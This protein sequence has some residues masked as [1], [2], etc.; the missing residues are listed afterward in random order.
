[1]KQTGAIQV[2]IQIVAQKL[3]AAWNEELKARRQ[4]LEMR[5]EITPHHLY[6]IFSPKILHSERSLQRLKKIPFILATEPEAK[7]PHKGDHPTGTMQ[8]RDWYSAM[9]KARAARRRISVANAWKEHTK[10]E[11]CFET[12]DSLWLNGTSHLPFSIYSLPSQFSTQMGQSAR[13]LLTSVRNLVYL[14]VG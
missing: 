4:P 5:H 8:F 13:P 12:R 6:M 2:Q 1:M 11:G 10:T 7:V 14:F 3:N 9:V